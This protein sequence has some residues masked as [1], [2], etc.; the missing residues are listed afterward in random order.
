MAS[1]PDENNPPRNN[2]NRKSSNG[3]NVHRR[4][5][6]GANRNTGP[7][8]RPFAVMIPQPSSRPLLNP[9]QNLDS[10]FVPVSNSLPNP[11][12]PDSDPDFSTTSSTTERPLTKTASYRINKKSGPYDGWQL[13]FPEIGN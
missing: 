10:N 4:S 1:N 8:Q 6:H 5:W 9:S 13:Y 2:N 7:K 11:A 12:P 3:S